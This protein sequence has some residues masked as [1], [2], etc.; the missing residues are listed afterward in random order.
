MIVF[1]FNTLGGGSKK[2]FLQFF[3][4]KSILPMFSSK[5]FRISGLKFRSLIHFE[6]VFLY[7]VRECSN[8]VLLHVAVQFSQHHLLKRLSFLYCILSLHCTLS[9]LS[10]MRWLYM[11]RF[12]SGLSIQFHWCIFLFHTSTTLSS[13]L[14]LWSIVQGWEAWFF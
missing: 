2:I 5:S 14:Q 1:I 8:F 12:I 3:M 11:H 7:G 4:S 10:Q 9:F 13:L 6:F